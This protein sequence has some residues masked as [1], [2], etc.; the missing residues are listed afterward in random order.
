ML[1]LAARALMAY[2]FIVAGYG[3][4][5]GY[6][7]TQGYMESMGVPGF[8]LPLVILVEFGGGL[9]LLFGFQTRA[10]AA[11]L[12]GFSVISGIIFH[13]GSA[14]QM[15]QIMFMKNLAMAG[16]LLAF[17]RTG[18]GKPALDGA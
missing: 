7:G 3:K 9:A 8:M 15:Q 2:I 12:A 5:V 6:A 14:D 11:A 16:G 10:A 17:V 4:I 13:A 1:A 18:A